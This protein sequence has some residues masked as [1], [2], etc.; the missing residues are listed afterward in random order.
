[1]CSRR[2]LNLAKIVQALQTDV[3]KAEPLADHVRK[4]QTQLAM[5]FRPAMKA[6]YALEAKQLIR[7]KELYDSVKAIAFRVSKVGE[8]FL[9]LAI[10]LA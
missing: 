1:M 2:Q 6:A 3:H 10:K 5:V 8:K 7:K 4:T 9:H